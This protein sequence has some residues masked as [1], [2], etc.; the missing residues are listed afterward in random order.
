MRKGKEERREK[1]GWVGGILGVGDPAGILF[2][3][4]MISLSDQRVGLCLGWDRGGHW[5][6][7]IWTDDHLSFSDDFN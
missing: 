1:E 7:L 2:D 6:I 3:D 4:H 5:S